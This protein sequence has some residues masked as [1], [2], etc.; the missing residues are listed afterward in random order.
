M[1][2]LVRPDAS[3]LGRS[4]KNINLLE[5]PYEV[6]ISPSLICETT[7]SPSLVPD[8][9]DITSLPRH[10]MVPSFRTYGEAVDFFGKTFE[11]RKGHPY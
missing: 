7:V 10:A 9:G 8:I 1:C 3:Y 6:E 11:V 5:H 4:L 2:D